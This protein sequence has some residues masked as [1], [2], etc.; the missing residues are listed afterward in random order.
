MQENV[1]DQNKLLRDGIDANLNKK[2]FREALAATEEWPTVDTYAKQQNAYLYL[3][4]WISPSAPI[5][6]FDLPGGDVFSNPVLIFDSAADEKEFVAAQ[7][8]IGGFYLTTTT[9][10]TNQLLVEQKCNVQKRQKD[11]KA[12]RQILLEAIGQKLPV[13]II[14]AHLVLLFVAEE[15]ETGIVGYENERNNNA[16]LS[17]LISFCS[18]LPLAGLDLD[19]PYV[20][21]TAAPFFMKKQIRLERVKPEEKQT[22]PDLKVRLRLTRY[23]RPHGILYETHRPISTL[24][25]LEDKVFT[26]IQRE[27]SGQKFRVALYRGHPYLVTN[28]VVCFL[29]SYHVPLQVTV[30]LRLQGVQTRVLYKI[31]KEETRSETIVLPLGRFFGNTDEKEAKM[32]NAPTPNN[33]VD[34]SLVDE[35]T[36]ELEY[37]DGDTGAEEKNKE[38]QVFLDTKNILRVHHGCADTVFLT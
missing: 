15:G 38:Y 29:F 35:L 30:G 4:P 32:Y 14:I 31:K 8:V 11:L 3:T 20:F 28:V 18:V 24:V 16:E 22:L 23:T 2:L 13:D 12:V 36:L 34:F 26:H 21:D 27:R 17:E 25:E 9:Y 5:I 6:T 10:L 7:L 19:A 37:D 33:S 1:Q